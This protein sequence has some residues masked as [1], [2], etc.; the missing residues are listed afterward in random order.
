MERVIWKQIMDVIGS[1]VQQGKLVT[2]LIEGPSTLQV[3][4]GDRSTLAQGVPLDA[5]ANSMALTSMPTWESH[6]GA[7]VLVARKEWFSMFE[8]LYGGQELVH[9]PHFNPISCLL[10]WLFFISC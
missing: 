8:M 6:P 2:N 3:T 10:T 4:A 5:F 1:P 9:L 7:V